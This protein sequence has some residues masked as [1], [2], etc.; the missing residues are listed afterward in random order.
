MTRWRPLPLALF[1]ACASGTDK[2]PD[3]ASAIRSAAI[4]GHM[5]FL[6]HDLLEG[7]EAGTRGYDLAA[8]YVASQFEQLNLEPAGSDGFFQQV[9]LRQATLVPGSVSLVVSGGRD[10]RTFTDADH[11]VAYPSDRETDQR[12]SGE[13]VFAGHGIVSPEHGRDDYAGLD[14]KG[15]F[16]VIL[17]GPPPGLPDEV[18]A[19]IGSVA[20][21]V[22]H[23][24]ERGAIGALVIY[25]PTLEAR[26][27][28][29]R[30]APVTHEPTADWS[31]NTVAQTGAPDLRM[32][33]F[34]DS[35]AAEALFEGASQTYASV[36]AEV[37]SKPPA[38]FP[39]VT[40]AAVSRRSTHLRSSSPNVAALLPG[41]DPT[42]AREIIVLSGHLDHVGIGV[43]KNG[44]S[45]Y[46]GALDNAS[47]IAGM[48]EIA[49]V[50][51][52]APVRPRRSILFLAVTA[53]EKGL[54]GSDYF[55]RNPSV[56]LDRVVGVVNY[57]G[58]AAF[59][60]FTEVIG[61]GA[62]SSTLGVALQ[63]AAA[64]MGVTLAPDPIPE[65]S[66]FTRSDHYS[67][68]KQ[69]TPA[70]FV[71]PGNKYVEGGASGDSSGVRFADEHLHQPSDDLS[72]PYD[73]AVVAR[74]TDLFLRLVV[75][76]ANMSERPLW[77][78]GDFFGKQFAPEAPKAPPA[79]N[80]SG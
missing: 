9:P 53:E 6:A 69:G 38:G 67:F 3:A 23:A 19:H 35:T 12:I 30:L 1:I 78:E 7:R 41:S 31:D 51:A 54:I 5:A 47:G 77:Y 72:L 18:A 24:A 80:E 45:I 13:L 11:V 14:V 73:F 64:S 75:E 32:V 44:D 71:L 42:L 10:R 76:A 57:D 60:D 28:F 46:N 50:L 8:R 17:G 58:A 20:E 68:V 27:P 55:A 33:A 65:Q 22:R 70:V 62:T 15:R 63:R 16:V 25:T 74:F 43:P 2:A 21:Q 34:V 56:E 59:R 40:T 49:R 48:L 39:L 4:R 66:I 36:L 26:F 79:A 37:P 61:Y 52:A 29:R